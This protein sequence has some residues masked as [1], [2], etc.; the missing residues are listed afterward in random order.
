MTYFFQIGLLIFIRLKGKIQNTFELFGE[1]LPQTLLLKNSLLSQTLC[2]G[3]VYNEICQFF[4]ERN[5]YR[6]L[7]VYIIVMY[8][9][10][11]G[12]NIFDFFQQ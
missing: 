4:Y 11:K 6:A 9:P 7:P 10:I 1:L 3:G 8:T 2:F 5:G 12:S